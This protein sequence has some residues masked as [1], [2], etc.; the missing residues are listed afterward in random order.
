MHSIQLTASGPS[1]PGVPAPAPPGGAPATPQRRLLDQL[2]EQLR[3]LH[4]SLRTEEAYVHWVRAFVRWSGMRRPR[5]MGAAEVQA[6][7]AW[8]AIERRVSVS[9]HR[10]ALAALLFLYQKV[11]GLQLPWM[12]QIDRPQRKPR[13]PVVL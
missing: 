2:R 6:F 1:P 4:Y 10:Q 7:L 8:L 9:T 13:L 11:F 5:Q 12:Q 3:Y